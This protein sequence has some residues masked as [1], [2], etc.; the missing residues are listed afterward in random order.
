M[1][2]ASEVYR[3]LAL[4]EATRIES[5]I[6]RAGPPL[7]SAQVKMVAEETLIIARIFERY[8]RGEKE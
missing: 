6:I 7:S 4:Q 8:L 3:G 5:C 2:D 1:A